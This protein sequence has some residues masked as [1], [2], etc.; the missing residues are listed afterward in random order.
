MQQLIDTVEQDSTLKLFAGERYK[1]LTKAALEEMM[2]QF[3][4]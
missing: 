4:Q 3:N 2:L 1:S